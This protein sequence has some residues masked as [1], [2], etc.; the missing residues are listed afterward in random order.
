[1]SV[2]KINR[3]FS[4]ELTVINLG[5]ESFGEDLGKEGV[6]VLQMDWSPPAGGDKRLIALLERVGR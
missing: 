4:E 2:E 5:L 3:L 1:M 6:R